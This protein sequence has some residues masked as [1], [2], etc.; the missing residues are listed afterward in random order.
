MFC[1]GTTALGISKA[2]LGNCFLRYVLANFVTRRCG[3][4]K[5]CRW[6]F[7]RKAFCTSWRHNKLSTKKTGVPKSRPKKGKFGTK[8]LVFVV[9]HAQFQS[10]T[11]LTHNMQGARFIA[12]M[13]RGARIPVFFSQV[14]RCQT[15]RNCREK[16][17]LM[18]CSAL[19]F[20]GFPFH[21]NVCSM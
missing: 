3:V 17:G 4:E 14:Q 15:L 19:M 2:C 20:P 13:K 8:K 6:T 16:C 10:Q 1:V 18:G 11:P 12:Y 21:V 5:N 9:H 7:V